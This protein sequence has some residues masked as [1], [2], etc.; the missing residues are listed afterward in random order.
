MPAIE[1][2]RTTY[3]NGNGVAAV[4]VKD[5]GFASAKNDT[6]LTKAGITNAG[7]TNGTLPRNPDTMRERM[8]DPVMRALQQRRAQTEARIGI[9]KNNFLPRR[10]I[11]D[12]K[13]EHPDPL[14]RMGRTG[15]QPLGAGKTRN[16]HRAPRRRQLIDLDGLPVR[17]QRPDIGP[18]CP[19]S[20]DTDRNST[21]H[22]CKS[23][24]EP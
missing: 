4:V 16:R 23:H 13:S 19:L 6:A 7:I 8:K 20:A 24:L 10:S 17:A 9:F 21:N 12:Q 14:R 1:R 18:A 3:G 11:A 2:M 5:R 15:A 22:R